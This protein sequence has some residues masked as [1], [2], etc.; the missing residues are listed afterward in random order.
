MRS[1]VSIKVFSAVVTAN[2]Q[3]TGGGRVLGTDVFT[4]APIS[5]HHWLHTHT[6]LLSTTSVETSRNQ[7]VAGKLALEDERLRRSSV[8][9]RYATIFFNEHE[10]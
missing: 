1:K 2:C 9:V 6:K 10:P 7:E 8:F 5:A 3:F 4:G